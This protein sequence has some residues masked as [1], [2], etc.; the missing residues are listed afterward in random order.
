VTATIHPF[1]RLTGD[2]EPRTPALDHHSLSLGQGPLK[3]HPTPSDSE[4]LRQAR[5]EIAEAWRLRVE[6]AAIRQR[7]EERRARIELL[8][9]GLPSDVER[10]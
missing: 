7:Y 4:V 9:A 6:S 3:G 10:A 8:L 5:Q 2:Y 1:P